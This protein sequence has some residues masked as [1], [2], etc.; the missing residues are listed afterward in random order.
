MRAA[1]REL[2]DDLF[3]CH[4][5][6]NPSCV[7]PNHLYAGTP[8]DNAWDAIRSGTFKHAKPAPKGEQHALAKMTRGDVDYAIEMKKRGVSLRKSAKVLGV[9][10]SALSK[11]W[12]GET[13]A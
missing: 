5:C 8:K 6:N 13:W 7:N 11:A 12:R 9:S 1:G 10:P 3:A 2:P 4:K